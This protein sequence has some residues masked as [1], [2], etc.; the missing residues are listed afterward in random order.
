MTRR[1]GGNGSKNLVLLA[2]LS[3]AT[4][5][6]CGGTV[7]CGSS[8]SGTGSGNADGGSD[9]SSTTDSGVAIDGQVEAGLET[10]TT[11]TGTTDTGPTVTAAQPTFS[12][13]PGAYSGPQSVTIASTTPNATIFYTTNGTQPSATQSGSLVYATPIDVSAVTT[14]IRAVATAS[15]FLDST[16]AVGTYTVG[17]IAGAAVAPVPNPVAGTLNNDFHLGLTTTT[18]SATICFTLDGSTPTC[19]A[20]SCQGTS[21]TYNAQ[22]QVPITGTVTNASTGQV[23][24]NAISCLVGDSNGVMPAQTYTLQVAQPTI[25]GPSPGLLTYNAAAPGI[26]PTV[27]SLTNG[28]TG[29][30]TTNAG[31]GAGVSCT[32]GTPIGGILPAPFPLSETLGAQ[33]FWVVGCKPG[34]AQSTVATGAYTVALNEPTFTLLGGEPIYDA[35]VAVSVNDK[36]NSG[37]VG[38]YVCVTADG[39]AATCGAAGACEG[40]GVSATG[41]ATTAVSF[42]LSAGPSTG[43]GKVNV[44]GAVLQ[45]VACTNT[46]DVFVDSGSFSSGGYTLKLDPIHFVPAGG[47]PIPAS[48]TLAVTVSQNGPGLPYDFICWSQDGATVPD[49]TCDTGAHP[50]L[51]ES[52]GFSHVVTVTASTATVMAVGCLDPPVVADT[53]VFLPSDSPP[54]TASYQPATVMATPTITP[55]AV[56]NDPVRVQFVNNEAVGLASAYFCY[57]TDGTAPAYATT[58]PNI[59]HAAGSTTGST[60]CTTSSVA[61]GKSS[62]LSEAPSVVLTGTTVKAIACDASTPAVLQ[63]SAAATPIDYTLVVGNPLIAPKGA[64]VLGSAITIATT[65]WP[66]GS[67]GVSINYSEDGT[68]PN[69][70]VGAYASLPVTC[71]GG[72]ACTCGGVPCTDPTVQPDNGPFAATYYALGGTGNTAPSGTPIGGALKVIA[73]ATGYTSS[74]STDSSTLTPFAAATP[75]FTVPSGQYDDYI[76]VTLN[77]SPGTVNG[78][79]CVGNG[80]GCGA[81]QATCTGVAVT[82][83]DSAANNSGH[84]AGTTHAGWQPSGPPSFDSTLK[85]AVQLPSTTLGNTLTAVACQPPAPAQ[86]TVLPSGTG[87]ATY[88]FQTSAVGLS[89]PTPSVNLVGSTSV[90]FS[91]TLTTNAPDGPPLGAT[92]GDS[93][94]I[95]ATTLPL[96]AQPSLCSDLIGL[97]GAPNCAIDTGVQ[98]AGAPGPSLTLLDVGANTTYNIVACKDLMVWSTSTATVSFEPYSRTI[99][100][101]GSPADFNASETIAAVGPPPPNPNAAYVS[102]DLQNLYLGLTYAGLLS[103]DTVQAY[104]GSSNGSGATTADTVKVLYTGAT[105][106]FPAGF[107][108]LYHVWWNVD[109]TGQGI[110]QFATTW[111]V[112]ASNGF[113]VKF[114]LSST[115]VEFAIPLTSLAGVG[116]DLHLLGGDWTTTVNA[117]EWPAAAGNDNGQNWVGWQEE[118]LNEAFAPNDPNNLKN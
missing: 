40:T 97:F 3:L 10:G 24:V 23:T 52:V 47:T 54:A 44:D 37:A 67:N 73:C 38:E 60:V 80:A 93:T 113:E 77:E 2:T 59:C 1:L 78:W 84:G 87:L 118:F 62:L 64:V 22:T 15:G 33:T 94:Y 34:Y 91:E 86:A 70:S 36:A 30:E 4:A 109:N 42:P 92:N 16:V 98:T 12:P 18:G 66:F 105:P 50:T 11:D 43:E 31:I 57:T 88:T 65:T 71:A 53:N 58:A 25:E 99:A 5:L 27:G 51:H 55:G 85:T 48:G 69:C 82:E 14:T 49:C 111:Q 112:T 106:T 35:P 13:T 63:G 8:S 107:N 7:G 9:S 39:S 103:T 32:N 46:T 116:N 74:T 81:T 17:Q 75:N 101:T 29:L 21:Q 20:G 115:F 19:A 26:A 83:E 56:I 45:A 95:C 28:A 76:S 72:A 68:T 117:G 104:I 100:M 79:F 6:A 61:P 102:W 108:A 110:D 41:G 96:P 89:S 114:N 90:T